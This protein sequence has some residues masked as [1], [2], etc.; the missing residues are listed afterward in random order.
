M[1]NYINQTNRTILFDKI[2][3]N[4][5]NLLTLIGDLDSN[6]GLS[7]DVIKEIDDCLLVTSYSEFLYKFDPTIYMK[8]NLENESVVFLENAPTYEANDLIT[9]NMNK[10]NKLI[11]MLS[12]MLDNEMITDYSN[13]SLLDIDDSLVPEQ[14][15]KAFVQLRRE[16]KENFIQYHYDKAEEIIGLLISNY[17]NPMLLLMLFLRES[18]INLFEVEKNNPDIINL[19]NIKNTQIKII[20]VSQKFMNM[21]P[22]IPNDRK[23]EFYEF[24]ASFIS[25]SSINSK[26]YFL[27]NLLGHNINTENIMEDYVALYNRSLDFYCAIIKS[28]WK[29][30][31]PLLQTILG[32]KAFFSQYTVENGVMPPVLLITNC[33]IESLVNEKDRLRLECYLET[34]NYKWYYASTIWYAIIPR[35]KFVHA[36]KQITRER[37]LGHEA[38]EDNDYN[39]IE[40]VSLLLEVLCRFRIQ[41]FISA[42]ASADNNFSCF[43]R[44]GVSLFEDSFM[45]LKSIN[46]NSYIVPCMPNFTIIPKEHCKITVGRKCIYKEFEKYNTL[47]A[48][49]KY[50]WLSGVYIEASFVAAGLYGACQCPSYL[51][52]RFP[53]EVNPMMPGVSYRIYEDNNN[54]ITVST[55]K[56]EIFTYPEEFIESV[57]QKAYGVVFAPDKKGVVVIADSVMSSLHG[58]KDKIATVQVMTFI[59]RILRQ[60]TQDFREDLIKEFFLNRPDS[61][62]SEWLKNKKYVNAIIHEGENL[63]YQIKEKEHACIIELVL[64]DTLKSEK[65]DLSR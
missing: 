25:S 49:Y 65:V 13:S 64:K 63:S 44:E 37:F 59:E 23:D 16:M 6:E 56:K 46:N 52:Q 12:N 54:R 19:K 40:P 61:L 42:K 18:K 20:E 11:S 10:D 34:V 32:I 21:E 55:M 45:P 60:A 14:E 33:P 39:L 29:K 26:L 27:F 4:K 3:P 51:S 1:V 30:M 36:T 50:I 5:Y 15:I 17:N 62:Y 28:L 24:V 2:N 8:L 38:D 43:T 58:D 31:S 35:L 9:I 47:P 48:D 57:Q 22:T 53:G 41:T 7:D